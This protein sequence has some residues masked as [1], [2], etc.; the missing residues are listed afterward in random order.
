MTPVINVNYKIKTS[1]DTYELLHNFLD[2]SNLDIK[3]F[4]LINNGVDYK[5]FKET[6]ISLNANCSNIESNFIN[7]GGL[8]Y[9]TKTDSKILDNINI[10][11]L[12]FTTNSIYNGSIKM[13]LKTTDQLYSIQLSDIK[14]LSEIGISKLVLNDKFNPRLIEFPESI[15]RFYDCPIII[16]ETYDTEELTIRFWSNFEDVITRK[17]LLDIEA[18]QRQ[19][20][21][22]STGGGIGISVINSG[23]GVSSSSNGVLSPSF[24]QSSGINNSFGYTQNNSFGSTQSNSFGF[25]Q[26]NNVLCICTNS[27][28]LEK[29]IRINSEKIKTLRIQVKDGEEYEHIYNFF[30]T[31]INKLIQMN[32]SNNHVLNIV[33][34]K[35]VHMNIVDSEI[36]T[37]NFYDF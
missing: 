32:T 10:F 2:D 1:T 3:Q 20:I 27:N 22:V 19:I 30:K 36:A 14:T 7:T 28:S 16:D 33:V 5:E 29:L 11:P 9:I 18:I 21:N 26:N 13:F 12:F 23:I 8:Q 24:G 37:Y 25:K 35:F 15:N 6:L 17:T 31:N 4:I 34:E